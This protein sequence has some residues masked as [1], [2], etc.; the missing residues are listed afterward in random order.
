MEQKSSRSGTQ[1]EPVA[2]SVHDRRH[3]PAWSRGKQASK[4]K[5]DRGRDCHICKLTR[6]NTIHVVTAGGRYGERYGMARLCR[7]RPARGTIP[8]QRDVLFKEVRIV[9]LYNAAL[10]G[11]ADREAQN[12]ASAP[13]HHIF[14]TSS[15]CPSA[16]VRVSECP[17][18]RNYFSGMAIS[19]PRSGS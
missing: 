2:A 19:W 12:R 16:C 11:G 8:M 18:A 6:T 1:V 10:G 15:I 9:P 7:W 13:A 3:W 4:Q 17:C 14:R 5:L